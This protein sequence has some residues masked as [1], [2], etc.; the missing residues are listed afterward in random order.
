MFVGIVSSEILMVFWFSR[1]KGPALKVLIAHLG[2]LFLG[3]CPQL[4]DHPGLQIV[5]RLEEA[6][7]T[8]SE[9][10]MTELSHVS[11]CISLD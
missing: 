7:V 6:C 10:G 9:K 11:R 5:Y 3:W 4:Y 8:E 2:E 1:I